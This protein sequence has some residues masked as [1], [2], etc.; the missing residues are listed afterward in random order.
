[1][2]VETPERPPLTP[3]AQ[4]LGEQLA[5]AAAIKFGEAERPEHPSPP[6]PEPQSEARVSRR[7]LALAAAIMAVVLTAG[8]LVLLPG[9]SRPAMAFEISESGGIVTVE[10]VNAIADPNAARE[11]LEEAG[12]EV[13]LEP[14]GADPSKVGDVLVVSSPGLLDLEEADDTVAT[15]TLESGANVTLFYGVLFSNEGVEAVFGSICS[16]A[17]G[18]PVAELLVD[19]ADLGPVR[20]LRVE[21]DTA[22]PTP[23]AA[24]EESEIVQRVV[25]AE[26][27]ELVVFVGAEPDLLPV[28]DSCVD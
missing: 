15:F 17:V 20:W 21:T 16:T 22:A 11:Q 12:F 4:Q 9:S 26:S 10:V 13:L 24:P 28:A 27:G 8:A 7:L 25:L 14:V 3:F 19:L 1:M 2:T 23:I 5:R 18:E 6:R